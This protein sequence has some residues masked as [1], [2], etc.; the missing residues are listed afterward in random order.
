MQSIKNSSLLFP[1]DISIF[2]SYL[3]KYNQSTHNNKGITATTSRHHYNIWQPDTGNF[4]NN[5]EPAHT[6][7]ASSTA[8]SSTATTSSTEDN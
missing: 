7:T 8:T 5:I 2:I 4:N 3:I 6:T 1:V